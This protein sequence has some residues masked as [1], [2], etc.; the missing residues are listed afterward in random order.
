MIKIFLFKFIFLNISPPA[1]V[2]VVVEIV[3]VVGVV[4]GTLSQL[5]DP[6]PLFG[7]TGGEIILLYVE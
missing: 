6:P 3:V 2:V 7:T 1:V 4:V 5:P